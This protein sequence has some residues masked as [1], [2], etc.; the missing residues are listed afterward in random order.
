MTGVVKDK[1]TGVPQNTDK[2]RH[3]ELLYEDGR[4]NVET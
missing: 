3:S 2:I 1:G 4:I